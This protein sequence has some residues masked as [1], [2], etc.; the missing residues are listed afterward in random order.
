MNATIFK[1]FETFATTLPIEQ[2]RSTID[3]V[4]STLDTL[5]KEQRH[6]DAA[7]LPEAL[8]ALSA[9][10]F[11]R[12]AQNFA[13]AAQA[14]IV[15]NGIELDYLTG[16]A[17]HDA[18][19]AGA[20]DMERR[21]M[22]NEALRE[23]ETEA[24]MAE[25]LNT[26]KSFDPKRFILAGNAIFTLSN[27]KG[28]HL[29]FRVRAK[30][31]DPNRAPVYFVSLLAGADNV[32][33]YTYLGMVDAS[34]G[35]VRLTKKSTDNNFTDATK[36]VMVIRW[37]LALIFAG[38]SFPVGYDI[39]HAGRCGRCGRLLTVPSSIDSGIGPECATRM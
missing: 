23:A 14:D 31:D 17:E 34:T 33:D 24:Q 39:R 32:N 18:F 20:E 9:E 38:K 37:S 7:G 12:N 26:Q 3:T 8:E 4:T 6:A 27:N 15:D 35:A 25:D 16:R 19:E 1:T 5:T 22:K 2:L 21:A 36:S 10:L 29:T 13:I 28:E 11:K 30:Q